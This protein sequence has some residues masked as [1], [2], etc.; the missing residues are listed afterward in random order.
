MYRYSYILI[1]NT[2][3]ILQNIIQ[4]GALNSEEFQNNKNTKH[5]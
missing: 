3:F 1:V 2:K 4:H 5:Y